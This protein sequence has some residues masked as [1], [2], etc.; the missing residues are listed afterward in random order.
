MK[1]AY[2]DESGSPA[3]GS[4]EK[5][6]VVA[7]LATDSPRAIATQLKRI[8]QSLG[9]KSRQI[10]LKAAHS[11]TSVIRRVLQWLGQG[12]FEIYVVIVD[13]SNAAPNQGETL[14]QLAMAR[15]VSHCLTNHPQLH[16]HIDRRYTN[17]RQVVQLEQTIRQ[18]VSHVP[19]QVLIIEQADSAAT[20]GLQAVDFVAWALRQKYEF[21]ESWAAQM[22][23]KVIVLEEVVEEI[24]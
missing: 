6:F 17:R 15:I 2:I 18:Y 11:Q 16:V 5:Y 12:H 22:V 10:E 13:Q 9:L 1:I 21:N 8:R 24:K 19:D 3:P 23:E 20:P 7:A 14:Y 4:G